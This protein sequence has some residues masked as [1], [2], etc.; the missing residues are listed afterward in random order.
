MKEVSINFKYGAGRRTRK[1]VERRMHMEKGMARVVINRP[2]V[3]SNIGLLEANLT[4]RQVGMIR[5]RWVGRMTR[6]LVK[7]RLGRLSVI[8]GRMAGRLVIERLGRLSVLVGRMAGRLVKGRLGR[9]SV[10]VG[11]MARRLVIGEFRVLVARIP[12]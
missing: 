2:F 1:L 4:S 10:L 5:G 7:G 3:Q 8:V 12:Q 6:R 9:L 11:R